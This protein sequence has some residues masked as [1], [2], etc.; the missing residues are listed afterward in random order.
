MNRMLRNLLAGAALV[1]AMPVAAEPI[2]IVH[3]KA[4][5]MQSA[6]PIGDATIVVDK[7]R[8]VSVQAGGAVPAGATVIDAAGRNVTPGVMNAA[9]QVGLTEVSSADDTR[10]A[11][12][13]G[14]A[15]GASFDVSAALNGNSAL[16]DLARSDGMSRALSYPG[17][18]ENVPFAGEAATIRLR[19]G[20]DILDHERV[21]LFA[22]IGGNAWRKAAASRAAQ[23]GIL[24]AALDEAKVPGVPS[25]DQA[26]LNRRDIVAVRQVLA[27]TIPLAIMTHR[28]SDVRAAIKLAADYHIRVVIV[29]GAEA[30]RAADA[31]AAAHIAVVL[32]PDANLP[33]TFDQ[34]GTR[35]DNAVILAHAGVTIAF[36][37]VGGAL[38]EN[39]NAGL[40][41]REGAGIAVSNGLP[42]AEALKAITVNPM[43]IWQRGTAAGA[44]AAGQDADLVVWDGDPLEPSTNA[45]AMLVEGR[46]VSLENRQTALARRY[47]G[48]ASAQPQP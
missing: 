25:S 41:V 34:L 26:I 5:T 39:Y 15:L 45:V 43:A 13:A 44:I 16:V 4:W 10:D 3:A 19:E 20:A 33:N 47:L 14:T 23:W 30:W 35:Q 46:P 24:R 6:T 9:T 37:R 40:A 8:I 12:A 48:A 2:A 42:Y 11:T 29:G 32:D 18:S 1:I 17:A 27:G 28:E 31:L 21:A 22:V 36:G 38:E 7:G